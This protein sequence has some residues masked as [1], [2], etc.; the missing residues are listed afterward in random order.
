MA[1]IRAVDLTVLSHEE[2]SGRLRSS[3]W[4]RPKLH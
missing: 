3:P 4:H 1:E 2:E